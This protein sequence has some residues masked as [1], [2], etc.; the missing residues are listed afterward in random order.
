[1]LN[2]LRVPPY[3][4]LDFY[5]EEDS[6]LFF[7]RRTEIE[8]LLADIIAARLVVLF[9]RTGTG[10]SSLIHA[11]VIPRLRALDY[12]VTICRVGN[13][14]AKSILASLKEPDGPLADRLSEHINRVD[15][16]L[17]VI[18]DQFEEF[19]LHELSRDVAQLFIQEVARLY[20]NSES[21]AHIVFSLREDYLAE[22]DVF[23]DLIPN[24]FQK[25]S[26][27]RLRP[28]TSEQAKEAIE[29]PQMIVEP[30]FRYEAGVVQRIVADMPRE[31]GFISPVELQIVCDTLWRRRDEKDHISHEQY[32]ISGGAKRILA[33]RVHNDLA[34][35]GADHLITLERL[36]PHLS[37][38]DWTKRARS[39]GELESYIRGSRSQVQD[40]MNALA[41]MRLISMEDRRDGETYV[42]W[43]SDHVSR[44]SSRLRPALRLLWIRAGAGRRAWFFLLI[45]PGAPLTAD[46]ERLM[47]LLNDAE[48]LPLLERDDWYRLLTVAAK[49]RDLLGLWYRAATGRKQQPL[50]LIGRYLKDDR[51]AD[52]DV[53]RVMLY[54]GES[55][56]SQPIELLIRQVE[57]KARAPIA[58][59][60]LGALRNEQ[61]IDAIEQ[62]LPDPELQTAAIDALRAIGTPR[63]LQLIENAPAIE[64]SWTG[65]FFRRLWPRI[66]LQRMRNEEW[67]Q[68][69]APVREFNA[70]A[71][72]GPSLPSADPQIARML[73]AEYDYPFRD[74]DHLRN[75]IDYLECTFGAGWTKSV[76]GRVPVLEEAS[77]FYLLLATLPLMGYVTTSMSSDLDQALRRLGKRLGNEMRVEHLYGSI[78]EAENWKSDERTLRA[79][80]ALTRAHLLI[81]LGFERDDAISLFIESPELRY[82]P[83]LIVQ[84][85]PLL[86]NARRDGRRAAEFFANQAK[87][88]K[89]MYYHGTP[90]EFLQELTQRL[91]KSV[92]A[93]P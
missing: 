39:I 4:Y 15:K 64:R 47:E 28:L 13:D 54:L 62:V 8:I 80:N 11:G 23:R 51:N 93:S 57:N 22:M 69:L 74:S 70:V 89:K 27:L 43:V 41:D 49:T 9:A 2:R 87:L 33:D 31:E 85:P 90:L 76:A 3:K 21:G 86:R 55:H 38:A 77:P 79:R 29:G 65:S 46:E 45:R 82:Q 14:P 17:V 71:L 75:V 84:E 59:R 50:D 52:D 72:L 56:E 42:E 83:M 35:L 24:I 18:I 12:E 53:H 40:L 91:S 60:A 63:A 67:E 66:S 61:A 6:A 81:I 26:H 44:I 7:G 20:A 48:L 10:K 92:P 58:L 34:K 30:P 68:I 1:M 25:E 78:E 19:F 16:P 37:T 32:R 88:R 73:A 36:I 5:T